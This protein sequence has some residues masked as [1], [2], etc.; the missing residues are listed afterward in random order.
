M[1]STQRNHQYASTENAVGP[2][3]M[4]A[5]V[6]RVGPR[7]VPS[8]KSIPPKPTAK[9]PPTIS[10]A[11]MLPNPTKSSILLFVNVMKRLGS[12]GPTRPAATGTPSPAPNPND[13]TVKNPRRRGAGLS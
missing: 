8:G 4:A 9:G 12:L 6:V 11:V 3:A 10:N 5:D 1:T 13:K 2:T 7:D